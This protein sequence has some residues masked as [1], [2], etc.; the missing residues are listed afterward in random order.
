[1]IQAIRIGTGVLILSAASALAVTSEPVVV[2]CDTRLPRWA[3]VFSNTVPLALGWDSSTTKAELAIVGMGGSFVT[4][5]T[6]ATP[7]YDWRAFDGAAPRADDVY[8][9]TLTL[10]TAG[11]QVAA[12]QNARLAV[13]TGAFGQTVVD[14]DSGGRGWGKVRGDTVI[15]YRPAF[16]DGAAGAAAAQLVIDKTGGPLQTCTFADAAG[17]YGWKLM[18]SVWGIGEFTL[19]LTFPGTAAAPLT[20]VLTRQASGTV[21]N[22]R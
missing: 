3:T 17:Y 20:A 7:S 22:I 21:V 1:M 12:V 2:D 13:L 16:A 15:P 10:Y 11:N 19:S 14:A 4:N 5:F 9:L 6:Q 18:N 8:D